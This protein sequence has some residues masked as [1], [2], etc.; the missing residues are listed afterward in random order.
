MIGRLRMMNAQ[1]QQKQNFE[2]FTFV[3]H[4]VSISMKLFLF[5]LLTSFF[6]PSFGQTD[7]VRWYYQNGNLASIQPY[8]GSQ[9]IGVGFQ[10]YVTGELKSHSKNNVKSNSTAT[11]SFYKNGVVQAEY[12]SDSLGTS[13]SKIYY[14]N[15][16]LQR[17]DKQ[18][19]NGTYHTEGYRNGNPQRLEIKKG[20]Q[21]ECIVYQQKDSALGEKFCYSGNKRVYWK[22]HHWEDQ[23]GNIVNVDFDYTLTEYDSSDKKVL[24]VIQKGYK[25]KTKT[26]ANNQWEVTRSIDTTDV[27]IVPYHESQNS[28]LSKSKLPMLEGYPLL[29]EPNPPRD[30]IIR[31]YTLKQLTD[32]TI[33]WDILTRTYDSLGQAISIYSNNSVVS[34]NSTSDDT[35]ITYSS[36]VSDYYYI[37]FLINKKDRSKVKIKAD[38]YCRDYQSESEVLVVWEE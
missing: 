28:V 8:Q 35:Y 3:L 11:T 6:V 18:I 9:Y 1:F 4:H 32:S 22:S 13:S 24:H 31:K 14:E 27:I 21:V 17:Y 29:R 5:L 2:S 37:A 36:G 19:K 23:I 7:T 12:I 38:K 30:T 25:I 15:G 33:H 10:Y 26:R 20:K 16:N 34:L